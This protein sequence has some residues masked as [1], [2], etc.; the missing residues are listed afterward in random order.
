MGKRVNM[1]IP[2]IVIDAPLKELIAQGIADLFYI[3]SSSN[4]SLNFVKY[5]NL[6]YCRM[7]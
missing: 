1:F 4:L 3:F 7:L 6:F 5:Y 2:F